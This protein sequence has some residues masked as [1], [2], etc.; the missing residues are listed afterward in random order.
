MCI[1]ITEA[2]T[3]G[4]IPPHAMKVSMADI[5]FCG[6]LTDGSSH[7]ELKILPVLI[8]YL[9]WEENGLHTQLLDVWSEPN[10][11]QQTIV[12]HFEVF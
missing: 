1:K 10:K 6:V 11:T 4:I 5:S 8:Q 2:I 7:L 9:Y 12:Q 3:S